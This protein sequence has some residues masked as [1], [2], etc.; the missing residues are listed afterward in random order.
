M[1]EAEAASPFDFLPATAVDNWEPPPAKTLRCPDHKL[2]LI[3]FHQSASTF[4]LKLAPLSP[5]LAPESSFEVGMSWWCA[6]AGHI[7]IL[8]QTIGQSK[9]S[10][11]FTDPPSPPPAARK[12]VFNTFDIFGLFCPIFDCFFSDTSKQLPIDRIHNP[13]PS[14]QN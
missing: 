8:V 9:L 3:T 7:L 12:S 11:N 5:S 2:A 4:G 6:A 1:L 10:Q 13:L 14:L